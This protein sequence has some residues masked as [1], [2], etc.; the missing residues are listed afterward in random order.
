PHK[1]CTAAA[2]RAC[3][4]AAYGARPAAM[5]LPER[6][7]TTSPAAR[8][9]SS[10]ASS[11]APDAVADAPACSSTVI[12][13]R[14]RSNRQGRVR[15][16][17]AG[18]YDQDDVNLPTFVTDGQFA[19][20]CDLPAFG[21][22]EFVPKATGSLDPSELNDDVWLRI[23]ALLDVKSLLRA[24]RR[25]LGMSYKDAV[26]YKH[27]AEERLYAVGPDRIV[28]T[29]YQLDGKE[30]PPFGAAPYQHSDVLD[31]SSDAIAWAPGLEEGY[32]CLAFLRRLR[33]AG[34]LASV[35]NGDYVEIDVPG[36]IIGLS[37][38]V[39]F[40]VVGLP[41]RFFVFKKGSTTPEFVIQYLSE[42]P[43]EANESTYIPASL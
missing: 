32:F 42:E 12:A 23:F 27:Q 5:R 10:P 21:N 34:G 38:G 25:F 29:P 11:P 17:K 7:V 19:V 18:N 2:R 39:D 43:D 28:V 37:I 9:A 41:D 24:F 35:E 3:R 20:A 4:D 40:L 31:L 16:A 8:N 22:A 30:R 6:P 1:H 33:N 13:R 36:R 14:H 15:A 26:L